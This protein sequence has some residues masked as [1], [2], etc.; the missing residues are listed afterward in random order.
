[1]TAGQLHTLTEFS[2]FPVVILGIRWTRPII[3]PVTVLVVSVLFVCSPEIILNLFAGLLLLPTLQQTL[4][5][6]P[7][8]SLDLPIEPLTRRPTSF[9]QSQSPEFPRQHGVGAQVELCRLPTYL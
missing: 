2:S 6:H 4:G 3:A 8:V 9:N 1:M 7:L 5:T